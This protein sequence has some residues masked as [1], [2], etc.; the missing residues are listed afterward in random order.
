MVGGG[1]VAGTVG[2]NVAVA[3]K[4]GVVEGTTVGLTVAVG[5][6]VGKAVAVRAPPGVPTGAPLGTGEME[7]GGCGEPDARS[8]PP[9]TGVHA[10][11]ASRN[12]MMTIPKPSWRT[13]PFSPPLADLPQN[14]RELWFCQRRIYIMAA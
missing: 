7:A 14:S 8:V 9:A 1:S 12:S 11:T 4:V 5:K 3:C 6:E 10:E 13:K 2:L